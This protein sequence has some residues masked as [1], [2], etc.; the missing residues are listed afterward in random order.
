MKYSNEIHFL[1]MFS[2]PFSIFFS[3]KCKVYINCAFLSPYFSKRAYKTIFIYKVI[4]GLKNMRKK[5]VGAF[6]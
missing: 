6:L 2:D 4:K 3:R 5:N 1:E